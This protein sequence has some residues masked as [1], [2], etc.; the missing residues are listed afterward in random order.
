MTLSSIHL[1][2][3][4][5]PEKEKSPDVRIRGTSW[6]GAFGWARSGT[7]STVL[8]RILSLRHNP[9][10]FPYIQYR[11]AL[12]PWL[13]YCFEGGNLFPPYCYDFNRICFLLGIQ[14]LS[15]V[16]ATPPFDGN[17]FF[18]LH[19]SLAYF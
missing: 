9:K 8:A 4:Y 7:F 3:A 14:S 16:L 1:C 10:D 5:R 12:N 19:G 2:A 15:F 11:M 18:I 13:P 6:C 17:L